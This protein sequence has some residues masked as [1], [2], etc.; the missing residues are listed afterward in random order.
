MDRGIS[1]GEGDQQSVCVE[2]RDRAVKRHSGA[3]GDAGRE[4][5]QVRAPVYRICMGKLLAF[6]DIYKRQ[7]ISRND[8]NLL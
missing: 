8:A 1:S 4:E 2:L 5:R 3:A 7:E 6:G